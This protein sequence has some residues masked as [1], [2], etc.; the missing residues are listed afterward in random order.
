[1]TYCVLEVCQSALAWWLPG[2]G[3]GALAA[4]MSQSCLTE[5]VHP[6]GW[7]LVRRP[8]PTLRRALS[9]LGLLAA[10]QRSKTKAVLYER[11]D[12]PNIQDF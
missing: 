1:M 12:A 2:G 7:G 10:V 6:L 4:G 5:A 11:L 9:F 8:P 3:E